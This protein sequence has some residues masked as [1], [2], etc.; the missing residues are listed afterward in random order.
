M[1]ACCDP[2]DDGDGSGGIGDGVS[3]GVGAGEGVVVG[4]GVGVGVDSG[5]P[6]GWLDGFGVR[7]CAELDGA[8]TP[9]V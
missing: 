9:R 4:V 1:F 6:V 8:C 7:G 2:S 3:D 5:R